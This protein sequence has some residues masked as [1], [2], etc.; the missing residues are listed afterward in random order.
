MKPTLTTDDILHSIE[1]ELAQGAISRSELGEGVY[2]VRQF[3]NKAR[4]TLFESAT[5]VADTR[6]LITQ[7]LQI[8]DMHL[9]LL[10]EMAAAI[11]S[12]TLDVRRLGA[13]P[14]RPGAASV[15]DIETT[16]RRSAPR[17][18]VPPPPL[19]LSDEGDIIGLASE[20]IE[21]AMHPNALKI[22]PDV[23]PSTTPLIGGFMRRVRAAFHNL[24]LFY[25]NQIAQ[26][27]TTVNQVYGQRLVQLSQLVVEQQQE[28]IALRAQVAALQRTPDV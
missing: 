6:A 15:T 27:Q 20:P 28:I 16:G 12:L 22:K 19:D 26:K 21:N 10:Q 25:L 7:Q 14:S 2:A 1:F 5:A 8:D 9:T 23:R 3:Q 11:Q 13:L 17:A 24:T 18:A 4:T